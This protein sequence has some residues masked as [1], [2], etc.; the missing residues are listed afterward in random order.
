MPHVL[1]SYQCTYLQILILYIVIKECFLFSGKNKTMVQLFVRVQELYT[2]E[3]SGTGTVGDIKGRVAELEGLALADI[4]MYCGGQPL[5]NDFVLSVCASD[6][7]RVEDEVRMFGGEMI[8]Y[9]L[10]I[11]ISMLD[12]TA[13]SS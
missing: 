5:E 1:N 2:F 8:T 7:S 9:C 13:S 12:R 10:C 4:S 3:V 11:Y 6:L